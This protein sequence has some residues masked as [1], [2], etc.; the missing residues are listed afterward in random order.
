MIADAYTYHE[1]V[2]QLHTH[3]YM[4]CNDCCDL[5]VLALHISAAV[6]CSRIA[7]PASV[8]LKRSSAHAHERWIFLN[9]TRAHAHESHARVL[10][11]NPD[12]VTTSRP[13]SKPFTYLPFTFMFFHVLLCQAWEMHG[14]WCF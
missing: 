14:L 13:P 6:Y 7:L 2:T 8:V 9:P 11:Y 1:Y 4:A 3:M 10:L 5:S 12:T